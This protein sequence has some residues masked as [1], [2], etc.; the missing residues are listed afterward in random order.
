MSERESF[1]LG[2]E[3]EVMVGSIK[4]VRRYLI[5]PLGGYFP[6]LIK[7]M[8]GELA[9]VFRMGDYH[10]GQRSRIEIS[11]SN[12]GGKTWT[13]PRVVTCSETD[14]RNPALCQLRDGTLLLAF[15]RLWGYRRGRV[16]ERS[17]WRFEILITRSRDMG[18]SWSEPTPIEIEDSSL[19]LKPLSSPYGRMI[20]LEDGTILMAVYSGEDGSDGLYSSY[21]LRSEDDGYTW[22]DATLI[23]R[24]YSET[25]I[26]QLPDGEL[27]AALRG[28]YP[29]EDQCVSISRS[30]DLGYT[31]TEPVRVTRGG[32]HPGDLCLLESGSLLLTFGH[33]R[34][35]YGVHA[36][37]SRDGGRTWLFDRRA[38]LVSYATDRDCGYPSTVQ[39]DDGTIYTAYYATT[40]LKFREFGIHAA[41]VAY[42]EELFL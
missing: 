4:R 39:L 31:W 6:V 27:V 32:E 5:T 19:N 9:A 15:G 42:R 30:K 14:D 33:R 10:I 38:A 41:G 13:M 11:K 7:M 12:D 35:P 37:I 23:A 18:D 28:P 26:I 40:C 24:G 8:N 3:D 34:V 29:G 36:V 2:F 22:G 1:G 20:Q 21:I 25:A 17:R 16:I